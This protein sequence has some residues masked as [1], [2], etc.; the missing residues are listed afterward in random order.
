M[1]TAKCF[2]NPENVN[3][4]AL[5]GKCFPSPVLE[6]IKFFA[7]V[8]NCQEARKLMIEIVM[9]ESPLCLSCGSAD[10]AVSMELAGKVVRDTPSAVSWEHVITSHQCP[11]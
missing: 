3:C 6:K 7:P 11:C 4:L 8:W 1:I 2:T 9:C 10:G 5:D